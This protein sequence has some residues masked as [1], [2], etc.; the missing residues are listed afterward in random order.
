[1][2]T[3]LSFVALSIFSA[4][5][6]SQ[7]AAADTF[8]R[9]DQS[10]TWGG[11]S[12]F[13]GEL[14][15]QECIEIGAGPSDG[16]GIDYAGTGINMELQ[17]GSIVSVLGYL[18]DSNVNS[19]ATVFVGKVT[20]I[21][22]DG[23]VFNAP[24]LATNIN[25]N[26]DGLVRVQ[27]G[28]T[29]KD[30]TVN[31]GKAY[32]SNSGTTDYAGLAVN[33]T[34]SNGGNLYAYLGGISEGTQV[35]SQ[36]FEYVQQTGQSTGTVVNSGGVQMLTSAGTAI[37]TTVNAGG[38]Q[39]ISSNSIAEGSVIN[40]DGL[41][42]VINTGTANNT[43]VRGTQFIFMNNSVAG[44]AT[45]TKLYDG[46]V[47]NIQQGGKAIGVELFD[48][49]IQKVLA[50]SFAENVVIN[51]NAKSW[52]TANGKIFNTTVNDQGQLQLV[53]G[54]GASG[55]YADSVNLNG[56]DA[57]LFVIANA[58]D[59][60]SVQ[61]DRL[62]GNG[63]VQ[64]K[65]TAA[66]DDTLTYSQLNVDN[67]SGNMHF[68]FNTSIENGRGDYLTIKQSSGQHLV[69][70]ADSGVEITDPM[71]RSLDLITDTDGGSSFSLASLGGTQINA[72]DGG[73]Y[74]YYLN[75]R[76]ES[77]KGEIWY[78]SAKEGEAV[79][80]EPEPQPEPE[81]GG[82]IPGGIIP[83][84][85][86][87]IPGEIPG[88]GGI[89][90]PGTDAILS[91]ASAPQL[92]FNNELN[93]L[94][95]RKGALQQNDGAAGAWVRTIGNKTNVSSDHTHFKMEQSGLEIGADKVVSYESG[96]AF[97]G[98]FTSYGNVDVKH[99]RGGTSKVDSYSV[100]VYATYFDRSGVYIDSVLKYNHFKNDLQAQ[101]TNGS[102]INGSYNQ[103]AL[104]GSVE[105]GYNTMVADSFWIEPYSKLSYVQVQGKDV[106]LNNGMKANINNQDSLNTELGINIGKDFTVGAS[107]VVTPYAKVAWNHEYIDNNTT[108]I[109]HRN[110][111][112]TNLS[113]D[114]AKVGLG[115]NASLSK[116]VSLFAEMDYSKGN[117]IENPIAANL[118]LRYNF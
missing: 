79:T 68:F 8:C 59:T 83:L 47:Q 44:T 67:L 64:F 81:P 32:I 24:A 10:A 86:V 98:G 115:V 101:S 17:D 100:G 84:P 77:G 11:G 88:T 95:F 73:T 93:N 13:E 1:M 20:Q 108:V 70:V 103:N 111:F 62:E 46:G 42:Y 27:D 45:N 21:A 52:V 118:G 91:M 104:G 80:P 29:L 6:F 78:L 61:I 5:T 38:K 102:A 30:S 53:A 65:T 22:W 74:M 89:T 26:T 2:K 99:Q 14:T 25:I 40:K 66:S 94:R 18:K 87:E 114:V 41:Q 23:Y 107:S 35:N 7:T 9:A 110:S 69:T 76:T 39:Q 50:D 51:N 31:G 105:V 75:N 113:G 34:V 37:N 49:S 3:K 33:N 97:F 72:V 112:N 57:A 58:N 109:N 85:E 60:D 12:T 117:K 55:A 48:N 4:L 82:E 71:Q 90:T 28:G 15:G 16:N 116:Q 63:K 36:G 54:E 96:K 43:I 56:T 92:I 106:A 19:G